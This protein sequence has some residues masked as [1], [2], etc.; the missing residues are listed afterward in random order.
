MAK[1]LKEKHQVKQLLSMKTR[2]VATLI[3][4]DHEKIEQEVLAKAG[5]SPPKDCGDFNRYMVAL[6]LDRIPQQK[7]L[8]FPFVSVRDQWLK[9][10]DV[11][12]L[13]REVR[14]NLEYDMKRK[15]VNLRMV[16][17]P[18]GPH[19]AFDTVPWPNI[20]MADFV[21]A[22]WDGW[23]EQNCLKTLEDWQRW[24]DYLCAQLALLKARKSARKTGEKA[25]LNLS[26][27]G[28]M[29]LLK[30]NFLRA[31][32][33]SLWGLSKKAIKPCKMQHL[34]NQLGLRVVDD[35]LKN[36]GRGAST[37]LPHAVPRT[38]AVMDMVAKLKANFPEF[39]AEQMLELP[40]S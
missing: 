2:G 13:E 3:R 26:P 10:M 35:D 16:D 11:F 33:R 18:Y 7:T 19:I 21:R 8:T 40:E 9:E 31:Y 6:Y 20:K 4:G 38:P 27:Q 23:R 37:P 17:T 25:S 30:R 15:P 22:L 36:A 28:I 32:R 39:D 12:R 1:M 14:L 5:V 24:Q 29:G 34:L